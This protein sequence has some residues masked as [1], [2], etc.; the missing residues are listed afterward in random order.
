MV[1]RRGRGSRVT[2]AAMASARSNDRM[3]S[4]GPPRPTRPASSSGRSPVGTGRR[5]TRAESRG[6]GDSPAGSWLPVR[7]AAHD[8]EQ[9]TCDEAGAHRG[10]HQSPQDAE[11]TG[12]GAER[13]DAED[14][15]EGSEEKVRD[16]GGR[17]RR[18]GAVTAAAGPGRRWAPVRRGRHTGA[19]RPAHGPWS[20][21][22]RGRRSSAC[23]PVRGDARLRTTDVSG[24][25]SECP[26]N[27]GGSDNG[28]RPRL[29]VTTRTAASGVR[30]T[31]SLGRL[32]PVRP[33]RHRYAGPVRVGRDSSC[34]AARDWL[35]G[36][37]GSRSRG[38]V[39]RE[40]EVAGTPPTARRRRS[41]RDDGPPPPGDGPLSCLPAPRRAT[42]PFDDVPRPRGGR[43]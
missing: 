6:T 13:D 19:L 16:H 8:A 36:H 1:D 9:E 24:P 5:A 2:P 25:G 4:D 11:R 37:R 35:C 26:S 39:P 30:R 31:P 15:R 38:S 40:L 43:G 17:V 27:A 34:G 7:A 29:C 33:P 42:D 41:R 18:E 22:Y 28:P 10:H 32:V 21:R 3:E 20:W 12:V 14:E 23:A